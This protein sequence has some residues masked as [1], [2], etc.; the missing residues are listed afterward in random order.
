MKTA[1]K[2]RTKGTPRE[3]WEV[4]SRQLA[5]VFKCDIR[6]VQNCVNEGMPQ[7]VRN[8]YDARAA[9]PWYL[10]R[11]RE[12]ARG[13]KGLNDLDLARQRKT[14]AEA[15]LAEID[16]AKAE[17]SV[18]PTELHAQRLAE[19]LETVA[20]AVKAIHRYQPDIKAA[21]T[22]EAADALCDRMADEVLAELYGLSDTIPD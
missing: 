10:E 16:L 20:G 3:W 21:I 18:I 11:E 14:I 17:G 15:R 9:V 4:S 7:I 2:N 19:R 1:K 6:T 13:N 22:D 12:S 5:D 8:R